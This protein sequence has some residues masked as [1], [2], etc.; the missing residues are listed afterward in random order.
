MKLLIDGYNLLHYISRGS[1][2]Q[3]DVKAFLGRLR[4]Y[5]RATGHTIIVVFDGGEGVYRYQQDYHGMTL[6]YSGARQT[7]DDLIKAFLP[8]YATDEVV[9]IS[10]D[11]SL[12]ETAEG[13]SIVSVSPAVFVNSMIARET[14]TKQMQDTARHTLVKTAVTDSDELDLLMHE[15]TARMPAKAETTGSSSGMLKGKKQA[16]VERRLEAVLRKL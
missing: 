4:R 3:G 15:A 8:Q 5:K 6:W 1:A 10:D 13:Y 7:A 16:K 11:R 12:N 14:G 9:L 2:P